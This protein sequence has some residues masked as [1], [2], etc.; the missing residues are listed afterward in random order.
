MAPTPARG[1]S[2]RGAAFPLA[3]VAVLLAAAVPVPVVP[4]ASAEL[5]A[6]DAEASSAESAELTSL[7]RLPAT[8]WIWLCSSEE[9]WLWRRMQGPIEEI[10]WSDLEHRQV[11]SE[12]L[13][14]IEV[15][16]ESRQVKAH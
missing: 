11:R 3:L 15:A 9:H 5:M 14:P 16:V 12:A 2:A 13:Q 4:V 8:D 1:E 10:S 6:L 7:H